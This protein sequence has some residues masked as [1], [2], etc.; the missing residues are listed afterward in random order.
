[1]LTKIE[2]QKK[3]AIK[4]I[5]IYDMDGTLVDSRHR[6][7]TMPCGTRID[8]DYWIANDT[9]EKIAMDSLLPLAEEYKADLANPEIYV[10]IATA[11]GA[12]KNDANYKFIRDNLGMPNKFVHRQTMADRRGGAELKIQAIK[13]LLNLKQFQNAMVKVFEDNLSYLQKMCQE[14][15]AV[16]IYCESNQGH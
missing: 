16:A 1:M 4:Q 11:R 8:L 7:R 15:N 14:L 2:E 3:M 9:P 10:I 13:P 5:K 6:Y 12:S